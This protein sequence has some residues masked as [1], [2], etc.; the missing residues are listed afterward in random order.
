[1]KNSQLLHWQRIQFALMAPIQFEWK[2]AQ[3]VRRSLLESSK[4]VAGRL[5][6]F[7]LALLCY[8]GCVLYVCDA[9]CSKCPRVYSPRW[10][11]NAV[12]KLVSLEHGAQAKSRSW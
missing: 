6:L 2:K 8:G 5:W 3:S 10:G 1:M 4:R 9:L 7:S 11:K 12:K